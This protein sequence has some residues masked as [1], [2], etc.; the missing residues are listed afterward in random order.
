M[1]TPHETR[2]AV[3]GAALERRPAPTPAALPFTGPWLLA[4]MEGVTAPSFRDL[5]LA[6]NPPEHLGGAYTEFIRVVDHGVPKKV[7]HE[8]LGPRRFAIPVGVQLMGRS[9]GPLMASARHAVEVGAPLV[10]L[11]FGCPAKGALRGCA[12]AGALRDPCGM[13]EVV[14]AV[15]RAVDG[16][17]PVT[18]KIRAGYD[19]A[20]DVEVL[21]RAVEAG[22]ASM[23]TVHC[24][25]RA[26]GYQPEVDWTRIAR[27]VAAV[28]IPV[29]GNGG[30][31]T[32]ADLHR[33]RHETGAAYAMVGRGAIAD[34]WVFSGHRATTVEAAGFLL[35]YYRYLVECAGEPLSPVKR[36]KQLLRYWRA[37]EVV[38]DEEDRLAW[39][40]EDDP[41]AVVA[42]LEALAM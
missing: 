25:T 15:V 37:G 23:L 13:E 14:R 6:R 29:C 17:V 9:L 35:E 41:R 19:N 11:N 7:F 20:D 28:S 42:R 26:E 10:D 40:R 2:S 30:I 18:G 31:D 22:G 21:A 38:R 1:L 3:A 4:P 12:G 32:H 8:H 5:V 27:A 16:Q 36:V 39:L 34:P 33:M 24:R